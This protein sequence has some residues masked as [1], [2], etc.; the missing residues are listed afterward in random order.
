MNKSDQSFYKAFEDRHRGSK[1]LI[2]SRLQVYLPFINALK[3]S[4]SHINAIDLGCGR[5]EWL[6]L[7]SELGINGIGVDLDQEMLNACD[8]LTFQVIHSDALKFL[9]CQESES[10][11]IISGFHIIEHISF[12]ELQ[13]LVK[14][15]FRILKPGGLLILETPNC[16]NL[17]VASSSFYLDPTHRRPIPMALLEFIAIYYGFFRVT[18][19]GLNESTELNSPQTPVGLYAVLSGASPDF[20]MIAQKNATN[21][22]LNHMNKFFQNRIYMGLSLESLAN[23]F[24]ERFDR[25]ENQSKLTYMRLDRIWRLLS[26][27]KWI[28]SLFRK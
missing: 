8:Q 22:S 4:D 23:H 7:I 11:S 20:A 1:D 18:L 12:E 14:E 9:Q 17:V 27:I 28:F 2:R 21:K 3:I 16:D 5:G 15:S 19:L 6:E 13:S 25:L 10:V 26:P 24:Q